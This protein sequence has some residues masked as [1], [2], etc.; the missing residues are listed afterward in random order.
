M[1]NEIIVSHSL[2]VRSGIAPY[3]TD[4]F[5]QEMNKSWTQSANGCCSGHP[6]IGTASHEALPVVDVGTAG[7]AFFKN[8]DSTN[9]VEI[10]TDATGTFV[11][12]LKLLAG[13]SSGPIRLATSAPYAKA[14][15][16]AVKLEYAI[17]SA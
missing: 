17:H 12:F 6:S 10:G 16:A 7:W 5:R 13:E 11:P 1:A 14:N 4:Y 3:N 15:T 9:Y 2:R 8:L